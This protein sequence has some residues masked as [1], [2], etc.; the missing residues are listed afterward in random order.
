MLLSIVLIF[1]VAGNGAHVYHITMEDI[2]A[3]KA[4]GGRGCAG[5]G[6]DGHRE[7]RAGAG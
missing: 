4:A 2:R 7:E 6:G 1:T 5:V 3:E